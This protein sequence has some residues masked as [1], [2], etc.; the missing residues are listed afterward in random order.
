M[1]LSIES[2]QVCQAEIS[3]PA[4]HLMA[5]LRTQRLST[6]MQCRKSDAV[7]IG[8]LAV[9]ASRSDL[10]SH[11]LATS[12]NGNTLPSHSHGY[13]G[14]RNSSGE[15]Y[16]GF[17]ETAVSAKGDGPAHEVLNTQVEFVPVIFSIGWIFLIAHCFL[18]F[19]LLCVNTTSGKLGRGLGMRRVK[20]MLQYFTVLL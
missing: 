9:L 16:E 6:G 8:H 2:G 20:S 5:P 19:L 11:L 4:L 1:M 17:G 3:C 13:L 18:T 10:D 15:P 14:R 12:R 7:I